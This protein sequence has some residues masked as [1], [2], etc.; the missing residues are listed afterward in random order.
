MDYFKR[1]NILGRYNKFNFLNFKGLL[2]SI[3][4]ILAAVTLLFAL[5]FP[6]KYAMT[7]ALGLILAPLIFVSQDKEKLLVGLFLLSLPVSMGYKIVE[8]NR[9][10]LHI[11]FQL[12]LSDILLVL[13]VFIWFY[14]VIIKKNNSEYSIWKSRIIIPL[15]LWT[16]M[17]FIS[18]IP[19]IDRMAVLIEILRIGRT[20]L[21]FFIIFHFI[22]GWKDVNFILNCLLLAL[23]IQSI[24]M[25]AQYA[26][27]SLIVSFPGATTGLDIV[28]M[29]LRPSGTM[30][31]S[32]HFAKFSGLLLPVAFAY[33]FF[34]SKL[35]GKLFMLLIWFCGSIALVL[36]ISRIGIVTLLF[37]MIILFF[38]LIFLHI[39]SVRKIMP[40]LTAFLLL[41][42]VWAGILY[43]V[44]GQ[45]LETRLL[46]DEGSA[47]A[48]I[49]MYK[50]AFNV[51]K[52]HPMCGVGLNN[53]TL[54]HQDYDYTPEHISL[55]LP[56]SPVH[57]LYL[58]YASE[59]GIPG[60]LFFL[61]FIWEL[62]KYSIRCARRI[63]VPIERAIYLS[64]AIGLISF[65]IQS[66]TG[67]GVT[68]H[69][70]HLSI[71][72]IFAACV[73]KQCLFIKEKACVHPN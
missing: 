7:L 73:A 19:A 29:G 16:S 31:H 52:A 57:N 28:G 70:I 59:I 51:I 66:I 55:L 9:S 47:A 18:L 24:L 15:L 22:K 46:F 26:T 68:D 64:M 14:K 63:D 49:P 10:T 67:K 4:G 21:T 61:W 6:A 71:V 33:F 25:F 48:R 43:F 1:Q 30:G 35:K 65:L 13:L 44:G 69:L 32:S 39:V 38:A 56:N 3:F 34:A 41:I 12:Y 58:L 17:G 2:L 62:L 50:V 45:R 5:S 40:V 60:L 53:Y 8:I 11:L 23:I 37:S 42:I 36:T 72:A 20:F 54:V 27:N